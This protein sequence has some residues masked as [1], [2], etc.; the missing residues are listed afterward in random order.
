MNNFI[1]RICELDWPILFTSKNYSTVQEQQRSAA[2]T[3]DQLQQRSAT[4]EDQQQQR[5]TNNSFNNK[6]DFSTV[7]E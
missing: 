6:A 5:S 1:I 4:T 7:S 2:T 3:K